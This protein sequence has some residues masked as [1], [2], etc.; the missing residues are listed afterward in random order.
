[1]ES[2]IARFEPLIISKASMRFRANGIDR[3]VWFPRSMICLETESRDRARNY[4]D[5]WA[6]VPFR[7]A[8]GSASNMH[9]LEI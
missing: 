3:R 4:Q 9:C 2:F 5:E 1:M 6:R 7:L 8:A